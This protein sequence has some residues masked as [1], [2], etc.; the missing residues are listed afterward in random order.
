MSITNTFEF[1]ENKV[2]LAQL[3]AEIIAYQYAGIS[4]KKKIRRSK[5][6]YRYVQAKRV[7]AREV[8]ARLVAY[9][10][11]RGLKYHEIECPRTTSM[12]DV[13]LVHSLLN[14]VVFKGGLKNPNIVFDLINGTATL[15]KV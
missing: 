14:R 13:T 9:G 6:S 1:Y 5:G 10:F 2:F 15:K 12:P 3:Q 7:I 4:L 8:R 11:L